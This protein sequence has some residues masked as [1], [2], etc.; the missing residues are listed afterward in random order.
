MKDLLPLQNIIDAIHFSTKEES[1]LLQIVD[2]CAV[3][4]ARHISGARLSV[5]LYDAL[6]R[7]EGL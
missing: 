3:V 4:L 5:P 7:G 2:A 6:T 1:P